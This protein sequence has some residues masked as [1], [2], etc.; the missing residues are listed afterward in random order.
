[1]SQHC[2]HPE[3]YAKKHGLRIAI[4]YPNE[5]QLD[6][7]AKSLPEHFGYCQDIVNQRNLIVNTSYTTSKSGNLHVY[8]E[9]TNTV[10]AHERIAMQAFLGSD[11][12]RDALTYNNTLDPENK[13]PQFLFELLD[14]RKRDTL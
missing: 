9:L 7:D 4:P 12:V 1:M 13:I 6:I 5:L 2:D 10:S 3:E 8:I 11:P 14:A